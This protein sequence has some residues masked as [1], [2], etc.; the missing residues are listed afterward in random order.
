M[1]SDEAK[2]LMQRRQANI[3]RNEALMNNLKLKT[4]S[5]KPITPKNAV[6]R[7]PRVKEE[8]LA[9]RKSLRLQNITPDN[10]VQKRQ[11]EQVLEQ[12]LEEDRARKRRRTGDLDVKD[13]LTGSG[14]FDSMG[15]FLKGVT[16]TKT[17]EIVFNIDEAKKTTQKD[18]REAIEAFDKLS[19]WENVAP[20]S[21]KVVPERAVCSFGIDCLSN[22]IADYNSIP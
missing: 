4:L 8:P 11:I 3:L 21:I 7:Q 15:N 20:N 10:V 13:L 6:K 17:K 2:A 1:G 9:S 18:V 12:R 5:K 14:L 19:L 16:P 22:V